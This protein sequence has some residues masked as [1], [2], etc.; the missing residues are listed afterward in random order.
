ME[1]IM[2]HFYYYEYLQMNGEN[3]FTMV[4]LPEEGGQFPVVVCRNPY[5]K[6]TVNMSEDDILGA[7]YNQNKSWLERGYAIAF[8]HCRGMGKSTGAFVPYVHEREDGLAFREWIRKQPFYS[9]ELY[10]LGGSYTSSLHYATAPFERDIKGAV[11]ESQDSERYRLWYRN[12]QMRKGHAN[13]HFGLYKDKCNL[14]KRFNMKSFSTLPLAGL[15]EKAFGERAEDFEQMLEAYSPSHE[16][17]NTRFGGN[18]ARDAV[19][20]ANIPILLTT[21]FSDFY[22]GGV[23]RMWEKMS[24]RTKEKSALLVSPYNHGDGYHREYGVAFPKGQR[25]EHFGQDYQIA[26]F[27]NIRSGSSIPFEKGKVAYYRMFENRWDSDFYSAEPRALTLPLG[28][29]TISFVYDP[30]DPPAFREEGT[31]AESFDDRRDVVTV[32]TAPFSKDTFVKGRMKMK[33]NVASN[34]PDTAFYAR[35]SLKK[36]EFAYTLCHDITSICYQ[37][38]DYCAGDEVSLEFCFDEQAFLVK[39][40]ESLRV[41]I[42]STDDNVYVCHTNKRGEYYLQTE[43]DIAEN[44]LFL[45]KSCL[46]LPIE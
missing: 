3:F 23:F 22:L 38:G 41:D 40:G 12:G 25:R 31:I 44:K 28:E 32:Y 17:W 18:D 6:G 37:K 33:L 21:G 35:V 46:V 42:S 4:L 8:Q 39:E 13:W 19:T 36:A 24:A 30:T 27:D 2:G 9:G 10:L 15:S 26:W 1:I 20:D 5:V 16:F 11:F 34:C 43:A 45:D 7:Y 29:Q 14:D